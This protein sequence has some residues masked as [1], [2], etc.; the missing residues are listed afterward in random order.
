MGFPFGP[1]PST[2]RG[3][4]ERGKEG[5]AHAKRRAVRRELCAGPKLPS[6]D[7]GTPGESR[8]RKATG[9]RLLRDA[10]QLASY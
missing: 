10:G 3:D 9:P 2:H 6:L 8:G 4:G 7:K 1:F 5:D